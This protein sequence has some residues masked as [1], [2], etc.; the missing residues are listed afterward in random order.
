MPRARETP[1]AAAERRLRALH[2]ERPELGALAQ[3]QLA[4]LRLLPERAAWLV[5]V[6]VTPETAAERLTR[7]EPWLHGAR[8]ALDGARVRAALGEL[9]DRAAGA[10]APGAARLR[11]AVRRG[12]LDPLELLP[13]AIAA[14][15]RAFAAPVHLLDLPEPLLATLLGLA[16][17]PLLL[18]ARER[19]G[20]EPE[21][22]AEGY[23]PG[24]GAWPVLALLEGLDRTRW[25]ACG[26]CGQT[27]PRPWLRCAYCGN[28]D[29][30]S[31]G[32]LQ[33]DAGEARRVATCE[34]C[35]GYLK[36][37][38]ALE[39]PALPLIA[40]EDLSTVDL[41]LIALERDWV[42]PDPPGFAVQVDVAAPAPAPG[43]GWL[44]ALRRR[45][46][47]LTADG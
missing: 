47:R 19:V 44:G 29:H 33:L 15:P 35:R 14:A 25:L 10:G 13:A 20:P 40:V 34:R 12:R 5:G 41:D 42:R 39:R 16:L 7:G 38:T 28:D 18:A 21:G 36:T 24:C 37:I 1:E 46:W 9:A 11:D 30:A 31:Q 4:V 6:D 17:Q 32:Y 22:W 8:L 23:C 2:A 26:R 43:N 27:W 45:G 3:L